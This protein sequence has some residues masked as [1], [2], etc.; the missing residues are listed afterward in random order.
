MAKHASTW[1]FYFLLTALA[2]AMPGCS[3][4]G[5][6]GNGGSDNGGFVFGTDTTNSSDT[7]GSSTTCDSDQDCSA[8]KPFCSPSGFCFECL[9]D[10]NCTDGVCSDG[11]CLPATCTPGEKMCQENTALTCKPTGDGWDKFECV[12]SVCQNGECTGC[13]PGK[14]V[15]EGKT[16]V[17]CNPDGSGYSQLLEC[18]PD[19]NCLNGE[20]ITCFPGAKQ[21]NGNLVETC[22]DQGAYEVTEDCS[23]SG[24][25]CTLGTCVSACFSDIKSLSNTG[26]D[27]WAIDLD[28]HYQAADG[29]FAVVITNLSDKPSIVTVE[30]KTS[31]NAAT[32]AVT[33][34]TVAPGDLRI[35]NLPAKNMNLPGTHWS[36]YR[37]QA[38]APIVAYQFNPLEN[39]EVYS[40]DASILIPANTYGQEYFAVS[41][42]QFL[43][44]GPEIPFLGDCQS[45]CG[46]I[47]GGECQ[48]DPVAF[49]DVCVVPYRGYI[50][51]LALKPDTKVTVRPTIQTLGANGMNTMFPG[52]E[53]DYYLQPFQVLN[54]QSDQD[55]GDLTGTKITS[56][57]PIAVFSGHMAAISNPTSPDA[58]CCADHLEQQMLP[59]NTW[60]KTFVAAKSY[61]R[62][63]E[64]DYWRIMA[65]KPATQVSFDPPV[66]GLV[67]LSEGEFFEFSTTED[68]TIIANQPIS[69]SQILASSGEINGPLAGPQ[70]CTGPG[71]QCP[72]GH[73]CVCQDGFTCYCEAMGDPALILTPP[74]GQFREEYVFLSPN[75]YLEDYINIV[76]PI[77]AQVTLDGGTVGQNNFKNIGNTGYMVARLK[78]SDGVHSVTSDQKIGVVAYGWD[79]DV[80]Y[81][82]T[83]GM[84]LQ[85]L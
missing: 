17:Q 73:T 61:P 22:N 49:S 24:K 5:G 28:N 12:G 2:V 65:S 68:F 75:K 39:V 27:Y 41:H 10:E 55:L 23:A 81:G 31:E 11:Y 64:P 76:A 52:M 1:S 67:N 30:Q 82:Y 14:K 48:F 71:G 25:N 13:T 37:I 44:G 57:A 6:G 58:K 19:E 9:S 32:Q 7:G 50:S 29:P 35:I 34:E 40:N 84:N 56:D 42:Y 53:Y 62:N 15:C 4:E 60:G 63:V 69:V 21:C 26:C 66:Q 74:V 16:V 77:G 80:S 3:T 70:T 78:V 18:S 85:D 83:A 43:G 54:I 36:A 79:D 47:P 33:E 38:T 72:S 51:V 59:T 46:N 20:C 45:I 8:D